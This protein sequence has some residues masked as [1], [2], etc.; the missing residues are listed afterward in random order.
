MSAYVIVY[1]DGVTDPAKMA[2]YR[3][4][5]VPTLT[6]FGAKTRIMNG[7]MEVPEGKMP[8]AVVMLEFPSLD[9][10]KTWY[11]SPEYQEA[12][13]H[14]LAGAR[15]TVVMVEGVAPPAAP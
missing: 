10:A 13:Q 4:L 6:K 9:A 11:H 7:K 15:C 3:R 2:E 5:G 12:L 8:Q 1:L 14:R